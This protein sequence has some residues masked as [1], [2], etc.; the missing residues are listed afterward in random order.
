MNSA[1]DISAFRVSRAVSLYSGAN[2]A[3]AS[4]AVDQIMIQIQTRAICKPPQGRPS[5][6]LNV[7]LSVVKS[8]LMKGSNVKQKRGNMSR[9]PAR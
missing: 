1:D 3:A 5:F 6:S 4:G 2:V 8:P 9:T 7:R